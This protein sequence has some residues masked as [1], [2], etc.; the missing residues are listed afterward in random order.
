MRYKS[1]FLTCALSMVPTLAFAGKSGDMSVTVLGPDNVDV[2]TTASIMVQTTMTRG[3]RGVSVSIDFPNTV[4]ATQYS[5]ECYP[6]ATGLECNIGRMR[7][8]SQYSLSADLTAPATGG[9]FDVTATGT[10]NRSDSNPGNNV[11]TKTITVNAPP[12]PAVPVPLTLPQ[13]MDFTACWTDPYD[14]KVADFA[15]CQAPAQTTEVTLELN[16]QVTTGDPN[17]VVTWSQS[18]NLDTLTIEA[19]DLQNNL[20]A[21][22]VGTGTS[23]T[24]FEG[25]SEYYTAVAEAVWELCTK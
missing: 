10:M 7:R 21:S 25:P 15:D 12:P 11:S 16:G 23:S 3:S 13:L 9:T 14:N 22:Y 20:M 8:N 17:A 19:R 2:S 18:A 5:P 24:C 4:T 6:V 1:I